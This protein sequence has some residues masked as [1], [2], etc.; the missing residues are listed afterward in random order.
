MISQ[1]SEITI[2][3]F[4]PLKRLDKSALFKSLQ[5]IHI[6]RPHHLH[7]SERFKERGITQ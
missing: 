1:D 5:N 3:C 2:V 7:L 6:R 4:E